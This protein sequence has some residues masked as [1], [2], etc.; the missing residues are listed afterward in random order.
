VGHLNW[1]RV[2]D[3]T[4]RFERLTSWEVASA[5]SHGRFER[6]QT[7][8]P[9]S[10]GGS[11]FGVAFTGT[12]R[13]KCRTRRDAKRVLSLRL[14]APP[15]GWRLGYFVSEPYCF[16]NAMT[17]TISSSLL[18]PGNSIFVPGTLAFGFLRYS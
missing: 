3:S 18:R 12:S 7:K 14:I 9:G 5:T 2:S 17:L 16:K 1:G 4:S 11:Y 15:Q 8:A 10:A 6:L 13:T